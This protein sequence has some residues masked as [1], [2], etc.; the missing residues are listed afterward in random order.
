MLRRQRRFWAS[1]STD[2]MDT[3]VE[4]RA[5]TEFTFVNIEIGLFRALQTFIIA[6]LLMKYIHWYQVLGKLTVS[7]CYMYLHLPQSKCIYLW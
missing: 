4:S 7:I 3:A 5:I 6:Q 2:W 1:S